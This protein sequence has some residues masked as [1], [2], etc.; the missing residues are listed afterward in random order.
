MKGS[1]YALVFFIKLANAISLINGKK[2]RH[3]LYFL[4]QLPSTLNKNSFVI[5]TILL[6]LDI[7]L[8]IN[9]HCSATP[10]GSS[11]NL[12]F[13]YSHINPFLILFSQK[14]KTAVSDFVVC[15]GNVLMHL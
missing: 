6:T 9:V 15:S 10:C 7:T 14:Q 11:H 2:Q 3:K 8:H 13:L 12:S 1:L 5:F 4:S